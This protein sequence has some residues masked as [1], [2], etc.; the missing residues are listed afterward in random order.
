MAYILFHV[1]TSN[2]TSV[3]TVLPLLQDELLKTYKF[4]LRLRFSA[5]KKTNR[6]QKWQHWVGTSFYRKGF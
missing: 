5:Q 4:K 2:F 6:K 3:P 1:G